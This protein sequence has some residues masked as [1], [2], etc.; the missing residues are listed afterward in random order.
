MLVQ[1]FK[2]RG[3]RGEDARKVFAGVTSRLR[4]LGLRC[5]V[6]ETVLEG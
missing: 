6:E 3:F 2:S 4:V 5:L 1:G